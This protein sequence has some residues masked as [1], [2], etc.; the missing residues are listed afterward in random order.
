VRTLQELCDVAA[1]CRYLDWL[2]LV[3][4]DAG[5]PVLQ[6]RF[7]A[8]C[9]VTG[10]RQEWSTRKWPLSF[11]ATDS[12]VVGTAFKAVLTAIEHEARE[13]FKW[14]ECAVFGPHIDVRAL[15]EV[16]GR[17]DVRAAP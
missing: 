6:W 7:T 10:E 14:M 12:E 1:Q 5:R 4:L 11:Y 8:P 2:L 17:L 15:H 9:T 3:S 13:S 16:A